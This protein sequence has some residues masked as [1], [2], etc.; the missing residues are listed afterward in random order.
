MEVL[1]FVPMPFHVLCVDQRDRVDD[2]RVEQRNED[3]W[4][5]ISVGMFV[6]SRPWICSCV[7]VEVDVEEVVIRMPEATSLSG[8]G[9]GLG[10]S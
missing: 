10:C 8:T 2:G 9:L 6:E 1:R 5:K 7:E 4:M 3:L